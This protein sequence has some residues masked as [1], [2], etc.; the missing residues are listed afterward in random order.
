MIYRKKISNKNFK[1]NSNISIIL[2][3][4]GAEKPLKTGEN[5]RM[6]VFEKVFRGLTVVPQPKMIEFF[7]LDVKLFRYFFTTYRFIYYHQIWK[8]FG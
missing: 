6:H 1:S 5:C 4:G 8:G 7:E 3:C 2:G